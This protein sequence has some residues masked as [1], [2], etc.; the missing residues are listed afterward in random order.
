VFVSTICAS[1]PESRIVQ[2]PRRWR[3][4]QNWN[5]VFFAHWQVPSCALSPHLPAGL[6]V[7]TWHGMAWVS[8][9]GFQLDVRLR[10]LPFFGICTHVDAAAVRLCAAFL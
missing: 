4:A 10:G 1:Q 3:W 5:N 9:V 8:V 2:P 7:D 6:E